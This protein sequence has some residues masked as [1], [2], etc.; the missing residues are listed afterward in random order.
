M[1]T[2]IHSNHY[3]KNDNDDAVTRSWRGGSCQ[4]RTDVLRWCSNNAHKSGS[5]LQKLGRIPISPWRFIHELGGELRG[6]TRPS[7]R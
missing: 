6:R 5:G 1:A 3:R 2:I 7:L 4:Q